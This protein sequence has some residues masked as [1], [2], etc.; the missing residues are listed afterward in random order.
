MPSIERSTEKTISKTVRDSD[1]WWPTLTEREILIL[2]RG[3]AGRTGPLAL[4]ATAWGHTETLFERGAEA[5]LETWQ[6]P[7]APVHKG[8]ANKKLRGIESC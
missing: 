4:G 7:S 6:G 5:R 8:S 3:S 1:G 2:G